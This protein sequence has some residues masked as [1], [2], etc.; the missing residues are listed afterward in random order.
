MSLNRTCLTSMALTAVLM[1]GSLL[2]SG[3]GDSVSA[4]TA[5]VR[6]Q[7]LTESAPSGEVSIAEIR[8]KL[9]SGELKSDA[10]FVVRARINAGDMPPWGTGTASFI[11]TDATGHDGDEEHDPHTC[12][13]CSRNIQDSL[14]QVHFVDESG[15]L[16][17]VDSRELFDLQ[18]KLLVVV[19]GTGRISESD[20][21]L[22][23]T[24][25]QMFVKR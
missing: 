5:A 3:C 15:S 19:R 7:F 18:E 11:V 1:S 8:Q 6:R 22:V 12:P 4:E 2:L 16:L 23:I 10:T 20:D 9:K 13:F 24:A 17:P 21:M 14:A 25:Q